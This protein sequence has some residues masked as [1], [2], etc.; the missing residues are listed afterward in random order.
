MFLQADKAQLAAWAGVE[1]PADPGALAA[2]LKYVRQQQLVARSPREPQPADAREER[3]GVFL[4]TYLPRA[5]GTG[6]ARPGGGKRT[7][8]SQRPQ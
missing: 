5:R 2:A 3:S 4:L 6:H 1:S 7:Q 8:L